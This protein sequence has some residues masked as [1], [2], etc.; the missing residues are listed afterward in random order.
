[1]HLDVDVLDGDEFPATDYLMSGG[2]RLPELLDLMAPLVRS[3]D[4]RGVSVACYNPEKD[5]TGTHAAR[6]VDALAAAF[7]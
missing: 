5:A 1:M 2:L 7:G 6:L 3:A 4:L